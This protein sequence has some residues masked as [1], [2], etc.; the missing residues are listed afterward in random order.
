MQHHSDLPCGYHS[1]EF[2]LFSQQQTLSPPLIAACQNNPRKKKGSWKNEEAQNKSNI[3]LVSTSWKRG[4]H[5][6]LVATNCSPRRRVSVIRNFPPLC[7][8][9]VVA[10]GLKI[11]KASMCMFWD[12]FSYIDH[13]NKVVTKRERIDRTLDCNE[14][15]VTKSTDFCIR[16]IKFY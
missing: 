5:Y 11:R 4:R 7:V 8:L 2:P 12:K 9:I 6:K 1:L 16:C 10:D 15:V 13:E 14:S 3:T